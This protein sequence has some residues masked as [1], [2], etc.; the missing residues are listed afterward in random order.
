M[1]AQEESKR[2]LICQEEKLEK[3]LFLEKQFFI[4]LLTRINS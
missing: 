4:F 1:Q 2:D 3:L